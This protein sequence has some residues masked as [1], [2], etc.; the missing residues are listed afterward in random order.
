MDRTTSWPT[1]DFSNISRLGGSIA[2]GSTNNVRIQDG[3]ST[4]N[5]SLSAGGTTTINT[6]SNAGSAGIATVGIGS[7]NTLRLGAVGTIA[8]ATGTAGL[9]FTGG[10]LSAGG[11]DNTAGELIVANQSTTAT[12]IGSIIADNGAGSVSLT[13]SGTGTLTLTG[14]N[15]YT[16]ATYVNAGTLVVGDGT[17]GILGASAVTVNSGATLKGSGTLGGDV[18]LNA[19]AIHAPGNSPGLQT[20]TGNVTYN[21]NSIFEWEMDYAAGTEGARGTNYDA[22]NVGGSVNGNNSIFEIVLPGS[23][24]FSDDFWNSPRSWDKI[25]TESTGTTAIAWTNRFTSFAYYNLSGGN[26]TSIS[27]PSIDG[28]FTFTGGNTLTWTAVP[29]PTSALVGLLIGAGLLRR[30][31]VA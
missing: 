4:G 27:A 24:D 13:K 18:T 11:A 9:T 30:R 31:R 23:T 2:D 22:V 8:T 7:G 20:I 15:T 29:E 26:K 19:G 16:G 21:S 10:T 14:A 1:P 12:R 3:G 6:L 28:S 25:F 5:V 17:G